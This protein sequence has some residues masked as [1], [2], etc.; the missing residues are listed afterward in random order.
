MNLNDI[1]LALSENPLYNVLNIFDDFY[2]KS[3]IDIELLKKMVSNDFSYQTSETTVLYCKRAR[4]LENF[5]KYIAHCYIRY[6]AD[7]YGSQI[8][9]KRLPNEWSKC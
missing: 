6:L 3:S 5:D 1:Y 8:I 2:K 7:V 9:K 4:S